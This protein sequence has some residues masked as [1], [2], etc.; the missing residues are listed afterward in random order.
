LARGAEVLQHRPPHLS[1]NRRVKRPLS[2]AVEL[3]SRLRTA[4][5]LVPLDDGRR[6]AVRRHSRAVRTPRPI[7]A[8][9]PP[10]RARLAA[11]WPA[12]SIAPPAVPLVIRAEQRRRVHD[13]EGTPGVEDLNTCWLQRQSRRCQW[14]TRSA[15]SARR[16]DRPRNP[17]ARAEP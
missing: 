14:A 16:R 1:A 8:R 12:A 10:T 5:A 15:A 6:A 4:A 13:V 3:F 2:P 17:P 7:S 11:P 9:R